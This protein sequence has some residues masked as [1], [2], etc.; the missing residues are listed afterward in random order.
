[1]EVT[2]DVMA[3]KAID[4]HIRRKWALGKVLAMSDADRKACMEYLAVHYPGIC[5]QVMS[6]AL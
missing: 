3:I 1:V 2:S 4:E 6:G 5:E